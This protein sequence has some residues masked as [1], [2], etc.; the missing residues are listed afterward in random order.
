MFRTDVSQFR[1][2]FGKK[3]TLDQFRD[4]LKKELKKET[5]IKSTLEEGGEELAVGIADLLIEDGLRGNFD[6][7][8][9]DAVLE[10][11]DAALI[12]S[13]MGGGVHSVT[14][15]VNALGSTKN[16]REMG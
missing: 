16:E 9:A 10:L 6:N 4:A 7:W 11:A 13:I 14:R 5:L 3:E 8:D 12:G 15:G 1:R 2:A